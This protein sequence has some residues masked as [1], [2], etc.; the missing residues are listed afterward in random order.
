MYFR[1]IKQLF[2]CHHLLST[3]PNGVT[4]QIYLAI[5]ACIMILAT[6]GKMPTKRTYEM[7]CFFLLGWASLEELEAHI[8][9]LKPNRS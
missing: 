2:G 1:I 7:I 9:K 6:T 5:I 8:E 3:K 4:I